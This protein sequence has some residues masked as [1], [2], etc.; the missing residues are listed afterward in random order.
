MYE[1]MFE[2]LQKFLNYVPY[3]PVCTMYILCGSTNY[4][5]VNI[6]NNYEKH[7]TVASKQGTFQLLLKIGL[8]R[9]NN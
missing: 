8:D 2:D 5:Q 6:K 1:L 4:I 7:I 9:F 3:I